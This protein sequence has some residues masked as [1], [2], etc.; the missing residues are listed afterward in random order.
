[1]FFF[2]SFSCSVYLDARIPI[3]RAILS[4]CVVLLHAAVWLGCSSTEEAPN[5]TRKPN[6]AQSAGASS[7]ATVGSA[8]E[9]STAVEGATPDAASAPNGEGVASLLHP[10][11]KSANKSSGVAA[12]ALFRD[13]T[14]ESG[15][16]FTHFNGFTG[17]FLLPEITGSG[18]ALFDYDNDGDLDLYLVQGAKLLEGPNPPGFA[19]KGNG[20][21]RDRLYRNNLDKAGGKPR[22]SDV[23]QKAGITATG[24][25]MGATAGDFDNDGWID[26]Y[27]TNLGPNQ[28]LRNN[29][30]GTFSD[31]TAKAGSDDPRWS[32]SATF[33]DYDQDGWLDLYVA[34]YVEFSTELK[35]E[36]YSN[37]SARDYCGP[38]SYDASVDRIF[39]NRG[40]GT[41]EDSTSELGI[42]AAFG[43]GLGVVAA[44]FNADGWTDVYVANDG[45]ANQLWINKN[46]RSFEDEALLA[47]VALNHAGQAEASMGVDAA[48]FDDDGDEDLFMTHLDGESNT[49][50]VNSGKAFFDDSTIKTGLH[51]PSLSMTGFGTRF[52]DYDN[53]GGLDLLVLNGAVRNMEGLAR[54]GEIYPLQQRNQLFQNVGPRGFREVTAAAGRAFQMEE[55]SRG[56]AVGDVDN[57]GDTD[58]VVFN[59][60]GPARLLLNESGNRRHWIGFRVIEES[61]RRDAL[62]ARV[63][64]LAQDGPAR[65]R[66]VHT[67][68]SYCSSSDPRILLGLGQSGQPR[69]A[70]VYWPRSPMEEWPNLA[71]DRYW[72][73]QSGKPPR[74]ER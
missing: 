39:H 55:V 4:C 19:W 6:A 3:R 29:G 5:K 8:G 13:L 27:V 44:D 40:N 59:N 50:Y 51:A 34:N 48:D 66:R 12:E 7:E 9:S 58:V 33:F 68:G 62:Q 67:D 71:V 28:M 54:Q 73:L 61:S 56:A 63:E 25:G 31:I 43:A 37:T 18:G 42:T 10:T 60:N 14:Q 17:E 22:F 1:M 74:V 2:R 24:Y 49:F 72:I 57:D 21:P 65:W 64:I 15:I 36:C 30:D 52:L 35:R 70:R 26:L 45:D 41:F 46:G 23:S 16:E 53:D 69:T 11:A 38:D 20:R 47:G 32:T